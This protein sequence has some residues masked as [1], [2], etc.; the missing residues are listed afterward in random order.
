MDDEL[1]LPA[2]PARLPDAR[3]FVEAAATSAGF[4]GEARYQIIM[5]ANEAI[6][7]AIEHGSPC[8]DGT[9]RL[10]VAREGD[11]LAFYVRDCGTFPLSG[12]VE[13]DAIAE[14]GRGFAFMNLLMDDVRLE[15]EPGNTVVRL[16]KRR[17]DAGPP[18]SPEEDHR[19]AAANSALVR[20]ALSA[21]Q[22]RRDP[23]PLMERVDL[24]VMFEPLSTAVRRRTPY[25]GRM[26]LRRYFDDLLST[27]D[28]FHF[29]IEET[30]ARASHV[31]VLGRV[32]AR[33]RDT[34]AGGDLGMV[35]RLRGGR[36]VW[37]KSYAT[38]AEALDAAGFAEADAG[39]VR[40]RRGF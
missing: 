23:T 24:G 8:G 30:R 9:L 27:W 36:I 40:D 16:A 2:D 1:D 34:Q 20:E 14:R 18:P 33:H 31:V 32:R 39:E 17:A 35:W 6:S 19:Q 5:A 29:T 26:G 37:G 3:A 15:P 10:S 25:L 13:P 4:D 7:N 22:G 11:E 21:F 28:E 12:T 38:H